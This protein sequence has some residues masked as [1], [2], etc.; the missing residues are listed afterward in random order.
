[1]SFGQEIENAIT[2][3][4]FLSIRDDGLFDLISIYFICIIFA[5]FVFSCYPLSFH[6]S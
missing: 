6:A 3:W 2:I 4:I 5:I 1:M